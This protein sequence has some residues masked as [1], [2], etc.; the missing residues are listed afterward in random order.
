MSLPE[1]ECGNLG[2]NS[3]QQCTQSVCCAW[4]VYASVYEHQNG[5]VDKDRYPDDCGCVPHVE[6]ITGMAMCFS[7]AILD[8]ATPIYG[9]LIRTNKPHS[10]TFWNA[11]VAEWFGLCTCYGSPC[12]MNSYRIRNFAKQDARS[13]AKLDGCGLL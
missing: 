13:Q 5:L 12:H 3:C 10:H 9:T 2:I 1:W 4:C 11:C 8:W 6:S 7:M